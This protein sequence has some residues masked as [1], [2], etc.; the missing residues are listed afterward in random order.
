MMEEDSV[1]EEPTMTKIILPSKPTSQ[2]LRIEEV[3]KQKIKNH[4]EYIVEDMDHDQGTVIES[5]ID[6]IFPKDEFSIHYRKS[7][8][9]ISKSSEILD[10]ENLNTKSYEKSSFEEM[11]INDESPKKS[12]KS[13]KK[14]DMEEK[15]S[16]NEKPKKMKSVTFE[17]VEEHKLDT[18][19]QMI[20]ADGQ[21][22]LSKQSISQEIKDF[23]EINDENGI[24][25]S[26]IV[27]TKENIEIDESD[28]LEMSIN[29]NLSYDK[30]E[31][32]IEGR[33]LSKLKKFTLNTQ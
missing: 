14:E 22:K 10:N 19:V 16:D 17:S 28:K 5:D 23:V 33:F 30:Q 13:M 4:E 29:K 21:K 25:H 2:K 32:M 18:D 26:S 1:F 7:S 3:T 11:K 24:F 27:E 20:D 15:I 12:S 6:D 31:T 8:M 9:E